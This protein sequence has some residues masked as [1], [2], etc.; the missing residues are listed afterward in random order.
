VNSWDTPLDEID[1][2]HW[3]PLCVLTDAGVKN[4]MPATPPA[5]NNCDPPNYKRQS[6]LTPFWGQGQAVRPHQAQPVPLARPLHLS[7]AGRE[8][9]RQV[10][11]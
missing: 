3:Q 10:R 11:G 4:G 6:F 8:A 1:P 7:R 9:Q 2:D 5:G